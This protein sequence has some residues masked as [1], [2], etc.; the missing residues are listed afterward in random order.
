[1]PAPHPQPMP[2]DRSREPAGSVVITGTG[3][4]LP[5]TGHDLMD[6][7]NAMRLLRGESCIDPVPAGL[8][9]GIRAKCI[10]RLVKDEDGNGRFEII[11]HDR[12]VLKLAGR[13]GRFDLAEEYG[14]PA[15]RIEALDITSQLAMA[16]GIDALR[17]A[18]IP[19]VPCFRRTR[20]GK[21]LPEGWRLPEG[22]RDETGIVF[23]S[24]FPG[25]DRFHHELRRYTTWQNRQEQ[26][27]LLEECLAGVSEERGRVAIRERIAELARAIEREPY[28]FD[29]R[30]LFR[31]LAMGHSQLAEYLG[32][33]GPNAQVNIACASTAQALALAEDWIRTGRCRRVLVAGGDNVTGDELLP[34]IGAG[35]QAV[36]A[37][38]VDH[39][40]E[41]AALPF[42]RRRHGLVLGMG[43]CAFVVESEDA[44]RERGMRGIAE[45]LGTEERNSAYHGTRLD[46]S[47]IA[48]VMDDLV[49]GAERRFGLDRAAMAPG[50]VYVAHETYTPARGGSAAAEVAALRRT[51]G[52]HMARVL[53]TNT[54]GFTGHPMGVGIEDVMAVK[55]LEH[56]VVPPIANFRDPDPGLGD[57]RLSRGGSFPARY[58][59]HMAAG[60]GS[61]LAIVLLKRVPGAGGRLEDPDRNRRWLGEVSGYPSPATE[62]VRR[63]LRLRAVGPPPRPPVS[64]GWVPGTGPALRAAWDTDTRPS[65]SVSTGDSLARVTSIVADAAGCPADVLAPELDLARDLELDPDAQAEVLATIRATFRIPAGHP[66]RVGDCPTI[67]SLA[68]FAARQHPGA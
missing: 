6:P 33:R 29:R 16:A 9:E 54:K 10:T 1:M 52:D 41:D 15:E 32:A 35:F 14:V 22:L 18:G 3:L 19:L 28:R 24:I 46:P 4:G 13:P 11:D 36:G 26:L 34:W 67:G 40:V 31:V 42:D 25:L 59:M 23:T 7:E 47:H 20:K 21:F 62:V 49:R 58:A 68:R 5:G 39:R 48:R 27:R 66:L 65:D 64:S 60:F 57:L 45:L 43:A 61:Q 38:A 51:F 2:F 63:T 17:E 12:D 55:I 56:Q 8:R 53:I 37:A 44:A 50:T 30:F